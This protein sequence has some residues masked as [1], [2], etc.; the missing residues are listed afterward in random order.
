MNA[1]NSENKT[2]LRYYFLLN[3]LFLHRGIRACRP[4]DNF[5]NKQEKNTY[6]LKYLYVYFRIIYPSVV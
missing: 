2:D 6:W 1:D 4:I 3:R 5:W